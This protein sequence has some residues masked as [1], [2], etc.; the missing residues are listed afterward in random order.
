MTDRKELRI[1]IVGIID[2]N[3]DDDQKIIAAL[4]DWAMNKFDG[5]ENEIH[6][7]RKELQNALKANHVC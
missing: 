1:T 3:Q 2:D 6:R 7:L 4:T 5:Y